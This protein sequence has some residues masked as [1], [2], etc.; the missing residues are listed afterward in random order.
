MMIVQLKWLFVTEKFSKPLL[1]SKLDVS[2]IFQ[3]MLYDRKMLI[4]SMK[5]LCFHIPFPFAFYYYI[6]IKRVRG[7][8]WTMIQ[9]MERNS[10]T[11]RE[12]CFFDVDVLSFYLLNSKMREI[13]FFFLLSTNIIINFC[14][15]YFVY[16]CSYIVHSLYWWPLKQKC[17]LKK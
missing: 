6:P 4:T 8:Q 10:N 7:Q 1:K 13:S 11:R 5:E 9:V 15:K 17:A 2:Y 16:I 12:Q 14:V 3:R